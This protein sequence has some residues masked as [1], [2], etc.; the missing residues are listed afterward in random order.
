VST[1]TRL[2]VTAFLERFRSGFSSVPIQVRKIGREAEFPVVDAEGKAFDISALWGDLVGPGLTRERTADGMIVGLNGVQFSYASEVGK[3]T[4]EVITGPRHDLVQLQRDHEAAMARLVRVAA[5]HG[6]RVL[7]MGAQPLTPAGPALMTPKPRYGV[8]GDAIGDAWLTFSATASD[9]T[10]VDVAGPEIV[11]MSNLC[12]LLSPVIIALCAS[13]GVVGG[14]DAGACSW[15][16]VSMGRIQPEHGRHGMPIVPAE[17]LAHHMEMLCALP[18][19]M[20]RK[21]GIA[22]LGDGRPFSAFMKGMDDDEAW[23]AFMVHDHYVWHSARPRS[24]QGTVE[25]RC[26]GQQPWDAHMSVAALSLGLVCGA[27]EI[28]HFVTEKLGPEAWEIMRRWHGEVILHGLAAPEP[29]SELIA[30]VLGR[31]K[32]ALRA[33]GRKEAPMLDPLTKRLERR[34]NPAQRARALLAQEGLTAVIEQASIPAP[35]E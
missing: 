33:R 20:D 28:A 31:A 23:R 18:H 34:E 9:Q 5:G 15:R 25:I 22:V 26:A 2:D 21:D 32:A 6:A 14:E 27:T 3:G 30:G 24:R 8:L 12:N 17:T 1:E 11:P 4:I 29:A 16:E 7:G 13:S 19:L 10:H 35:V